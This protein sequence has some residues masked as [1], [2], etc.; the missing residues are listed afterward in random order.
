MPIDFTLNDN[1]QRLRREARQFAKDVLSGVAVATRD[2]PSPIER[3]VATR[4]FYER[5]VAEGFLRKCIPVS[6]GGDC[7]GL[8][9]LA[10]L[11]EEFYTVDPNVSLTMLSTMLGLTPLVVGGTPEQRQLFLQPFLATKGAPLA[12]FAL[13]EPGGSANVGSPSPGEGVRTTAR[14]VGDS[15]VISGRKQWISAATGWNGE[16]ADLLTVVCRTDANVEPSRGISI[17]AVPRPD[18]GLIFEHGFDTLGHRAH[19]MPRFRLDAVPVPAGNLLRQEGRGLQLAAESFAGSA[20]LVGIFGVALMRA[21]FQF[22]LSFAQSDRRGGIQQI[23]QHQAVGYALA[24]AKTTIEA[25]RALSWHACRS[26]DTAAPGA[27]ELAIH[28]KVFGS[29]AAVRVITDLMRVVGVES[30][31][32]ELPLAGLLQ[33][34]VALPLFAGGNIGVR[35]RQLHA[36]MLDPAYDDLATL[37]GV[38]VAETAFSKEE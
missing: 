38:C 6:V 1:Q 7:A 2:L 17:I 27:L 4:P 5:L 32:H 23:I 10:I 31:G 20:A 28:A 30:Y 24:D 3:F 13:T 14:R 11:A 37:D 21:A 36:L 29:E 25:A 22:A 26:F 12:A 9:D 15:W 33:D 8:V 19:L 34:A 16:G 18:S 35:R